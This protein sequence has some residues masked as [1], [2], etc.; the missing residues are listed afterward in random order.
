ME[1]SKDGGEVFC[2]AAEM[3]KAGESAPYQDT[4]FYENSNHLKLRA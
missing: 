3:G 4:R 2:R 1:W